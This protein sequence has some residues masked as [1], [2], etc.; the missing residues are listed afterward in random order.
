MSSPTSLNRLNM[1]A[2]LP[3]N[4]RIEFAIEVNKGQEPQRY[5]FYAEHSAIANGFTIKGTLN[6]LRSEA[7][8]ERRLEGTYEILYKGEESSEDGKL[9]G[10]F[11]AEKNSWTLTPMGQQVMKQWFLSSASDS[12]SS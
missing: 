3:S 9:T 12:R 5:T 7:D 10:V 6:F 11:N 8:L 1:P 4:G 2:D